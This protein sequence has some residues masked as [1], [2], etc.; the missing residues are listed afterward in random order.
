MQAGRIAVFFAAV[1]LAAGFGTMTYTEE[2][3]HWRAH[4]EAT[5]KAEDGWLS[6]AGLFWLK[7]GSNP[8]G[9]APGNSILLPRGPANLGTINYHEG[10]AVFVPQPGSV[11]TV[12][13]QAPTTAALKSDAGGAKP[14]LMRVGDFT[15]FVIH[16]GERD[17]IRLRDTQSQARRGFHGLRW[18]PPNQAYRVTAK[19]VAYPEPKILAV[20]N[21]LG[22]TE[23]TPSPGYAEFTLNGHEIRLDPVV[24]DGTLFFVFRDTTAGKE[25]YGSGRFL[26]TAMPK[27]GRVVLDFNEAYNPPC[28]FTPYATCP[29]PPKQN[30][31]T[32]PIEAGELNYGEHPH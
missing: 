17:G 29:L 4:R 15:F 7:E 21:I 26:H 5:L 16:R 24:E 25:T 6:L 28:A 12:N 23:H 13:G 3:E 2:V 11:L 8:V 14:D 20:P 30:R 9:S 10:K 22:E 1:S 19:W 18:Y 27:E 32:I 31:L